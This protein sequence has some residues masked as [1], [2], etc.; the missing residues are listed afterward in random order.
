MSIQGGNNASYPFLETSDQDFQ[1][2]SSRK[3]VVKN[4]LVTQ[5]QFPRK[6]ISMWPSP[7]L[8]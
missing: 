2:V 3:E 7:Y 4:K 6:I 1:S 5:C 8:N